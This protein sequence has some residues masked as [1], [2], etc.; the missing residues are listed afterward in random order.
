M[1]SEA[2]YKHSHDNVVHSDFGSAF[3]VGALEQWNDDS[4]VEFFECRHSNE[5]SGAELLSDSSKL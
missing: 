2:S 4:P 5:T 1:E 3:A